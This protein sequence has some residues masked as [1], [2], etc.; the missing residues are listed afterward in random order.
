MERDVRLLVVE[1]TNCRSCTHLSEHRIHL[2]PEDFDGEIQ[3]YCA[4]ESERT[5][6]IA[7]ITNIWRIAPFC[8]LPKAVEKKEE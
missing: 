1:I 2:A 6:R 8:Q 3:F 4:E 5:G 7:A